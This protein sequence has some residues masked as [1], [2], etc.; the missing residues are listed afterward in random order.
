MSQ[1]LHQRFLSNF[2]A[3]LCAIYRDCA[4]L[5]VWT[6]ASQYPHHHDPPEKR[7]EKLKRLIVAF[8]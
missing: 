1:S 5:M 4:R 3:I 2:L 7:F 8:K 6:A